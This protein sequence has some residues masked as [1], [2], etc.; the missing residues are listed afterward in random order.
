MST[1]HIPFLFFLFC[2]VAT[3]CD[4][5]ALQSIHTQTEISEIRNFGMESKFLSKKKSIYILNMNERE[6]VAEK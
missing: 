3:M 5:R 2:F 6:I 4:I 1:W